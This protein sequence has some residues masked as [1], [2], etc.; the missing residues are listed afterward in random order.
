VHVPHREGNEA[1]E[2]FAMPEIERERQ[3]AL[4]KRGVNFVVN[5]QGALL[6]RQKQRFARQ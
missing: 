2:S 6:I 5:E 1:H 4:Q 3:F